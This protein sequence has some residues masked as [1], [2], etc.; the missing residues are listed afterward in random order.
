MRD[1][2]QAWVD[3][4]L[5]GEPYEQADLEDDLGGLS[6]SVLYDR[7]LEVE[8]Y[9]RA[10]AA[11]KKAIS[12][13]LLEAVKDKPRRFGTEVLTTKPSGTRKIT[14][15]AGLTECLGTPAAIRMAFNL[16][17]HD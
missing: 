15:V 17:G 11:W 10:V 14:D 6:S 4:E 3:Q 9:G 16:T 5:S 7:L 13:L 2:L 12:S 1:R 8:R